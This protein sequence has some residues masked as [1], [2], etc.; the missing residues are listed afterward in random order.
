MRFVTDGGRT[1]GRGREEGVGALFSECVCA[2][3]RLFVFAI[4][5]VEGRAVVV[6]WRGRG[7]AT[8]HA[9]DGFVCWM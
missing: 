4:V 9:R 7:R 2:I 1:G 8:C 3:C 6:M 5:S